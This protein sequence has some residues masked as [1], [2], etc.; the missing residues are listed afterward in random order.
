M[1]K[2][3]RGEG[4]V[5]CDIM[6]IGEA[7][8]AEEEIQGRPFV[9]RSGQLLESLYINEGLGFE[10]DEVYITNVVKIRPPFNRAP[11]LQEITYWRPKLVEEIKKVWPDVIVTVG[12]VA[13]NSLLEISVGVIA[14]RRSKWTFEFHMK[15]S[16]KTAIV[17]PTFHPSYLLRQGVGELR[18]EVLHDMER[19][20]RAIP[21]RR[22]ARTD[23]L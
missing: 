2:I 11:T 18:E 22:A 10:R 9:G 17:V 15:Y 19:A 13:T 8:G 1:S 14:A 21:Y 16:P 23:G 5:P 7:P 3:V 4:P 20:L 6:I 12:S